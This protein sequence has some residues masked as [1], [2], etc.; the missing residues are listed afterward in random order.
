MLPITKDFAG[1]NQRT[2]GLH[3]RIESDVITLLRTD[4][5]ERQCVISAP[6][7]SGE[8]R[9]V[10]SIG[11]MRQQNRRTRASTLLCTRN[12]VQPGLWPA[13]VNNFGWIPFRRQM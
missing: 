9:K 2:A 13:Q 11:N 8:A 10:D 5:A 1:Q 7:A 3:R 4:P 12:A 6:N